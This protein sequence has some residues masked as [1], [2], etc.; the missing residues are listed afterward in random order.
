[1]LFLYEPLLNESWWSCMSS[2]WTQADDLCDCLQESDTLRRM[3]TQWGVH[4]AS[5]CWPATTV[6]ILSDTT[7]IGIY[8]QSGQGSRVQWPDYHT[9]PHWA[10]YFGHHIVLQ[11]LYYL[12]SKSWYWSVRNAACTPVW[13]FQ[14]TNVPCVSFL[15]VLS[16][17]NN[18]ACWHCFD[19]CACNS[20]KPCT[21][22]LL[23][24]WVHHQRQRRTDLQSLMIYGRP[25]S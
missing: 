16:L 23:L 25:E 21:Y 22:A 11:S 10:I 15:Q 3:T 19:M 5:K 7:I 1:M 9:W 17:T 8:V 18:C 14:M 6:T 2:C 4:T 24:E 13:R 20:V 12:D